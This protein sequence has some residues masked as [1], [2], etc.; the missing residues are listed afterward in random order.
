[1][2][3]KLKVLLLLAEF[4]FWRAARHLSYSAQLG[5]EEGLLANGVQCVTV[6]SPWLP[7]ALEV[8]GRRQFDQV[9]LVG[10][11]DLFDEVSLQRVLTMAPDPDGQNTNR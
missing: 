5:V 4:P 3:S 6:T 1:M 2:Y 10:R 7:K 9:W 11:M 8:W